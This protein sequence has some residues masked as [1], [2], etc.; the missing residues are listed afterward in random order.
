MS[1]EDNY[2]KVFNNCSDINKNATLIVVSK[3]QCFDNINKLINLNHC[4]FGENK[5]QEALVKW[6][7]AKETYKN[8]KL[9]LIGRLQSNK[10]TK[11]L[12][13][14]DYIHSLDSRKL[15]FELSLE[16]NKQL[17]K[18]KY[19]IQVNT[20]KE[21]QKSGIL[22]EELLDFYKFCKEESKLNVIGLMCLPPVNDDP[23]KHFRKL[24][25]LSE[26]I[27]NLSLSMG[28]SNDYHIAL[29]EGATHV[30]VGSAIFSSG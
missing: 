10:I 23:R 9:H 5:V 11:A 12:S 17:K 1:L 4:H 25:N 19:F 2:R 15:A 18:I 29:E 22:E 14:F 16:E 6:N 27:G 13:L 28:M 3:S 8:I 26:K 20:G 30:R 21:I 7:N 24:K